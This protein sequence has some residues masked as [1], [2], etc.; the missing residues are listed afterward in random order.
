MAF[1]SLSKLI[2]TIFLSPN[3]LVRNYNK[4]QTEAKC[5][6]WKDT[7]PKALKTRRCVFQ[8]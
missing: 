7:L 8:D 1:M 5:S 6:E 2:F 4:L 3:K